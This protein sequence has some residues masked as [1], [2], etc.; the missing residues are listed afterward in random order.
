VVQFCLVVGREAEDAGGQNQRKVRVYI[1]H[2]VKNSHI[3]S[4]RMHARKAWPKRTSLSL[5]S[6][7][8]FE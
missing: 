7:I 2:T 8:F 6:F 4:T 5:R 1:V 3:A